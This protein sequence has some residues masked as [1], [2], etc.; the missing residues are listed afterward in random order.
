MDLLVLSSYLIPYGINSGND[1]S[2][3]NNYK[4]ISDIMKIACNM[5]AF[6]F[7]LK[8]MEKCHL[9]DLSLMEFS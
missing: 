2:K 1:L 4:T 7:F 6:F 8:L 3:K 9:L 5:P